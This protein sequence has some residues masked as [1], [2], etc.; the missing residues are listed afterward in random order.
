MMRFVRALP[1]GALFFF[2]AAILFG[3][4]ALNASAYGLRE[5]AQ[6]GLIGGIA[7]MGAA[8]SFC[9]WSKPSGRR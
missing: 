5:M 2:V 7:A 4:G 3:L 1:T 9:D 8:Y 6:F